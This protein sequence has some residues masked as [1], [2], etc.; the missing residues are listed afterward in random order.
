MMRLLHLTL[1]LFFLI[2]C[3]EESAPRSTAN[4]KQVLGGNNTTGFL[5]A[6][7]PRLF[8]FPEDHGLHAGYRNE[9]WYITGNL[10]SAEGRHFGYQ[11]TF[12]NVAARA[13]ATTQTRET[14]ATAASSN[15]NSER[16]WMAHFA[17][18][19]V[20]ANSH[21]A[22]E[23]FSR[24]NPG[25]AGAQLNPFKVWLDDWQLVG[26]GNDFPWHLK[27]TDQELSL[28]L[29]LNSVKKPVL[30]GDQGLSQKNQT[31]GSAS[32]YYS[33]TRLQTSGE[34]KVGDE[35][36]TVSGNSWLDREWSSSV[37]GPDQ[38]GWDWFSLQ[39]DDGQELMYYQL[40][41]LNGQSHAYSQ[42]NWTDA[43]ATQHLISPA[44]INLQEQQWWTSPA[45]VQYATAWLLSYQGRQWRVQAVV[46]AQWMDLSFQYW[47]GAVNVLDPVNG[48]V[49]G[50]GYLEM[51]RQ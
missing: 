47:E 11:V 41:N 44:D 23:R 22:V 18:T 30:Q 33:L 3:A 7:S 1:C 51:V 49:L 48:S 28:S 34:I 4:I 14:T 37:L 40:R 26:T 17:L 24:E 16:L 42:G 36:F 6:D 29:N 32:Y 46:D 35:L 10:Y 20:D 2:A 9:W 39:F 21:H 8:E 15:W 27:L 19:D 13:P 12:F 25:L 31:A 50:S 5:R 38:S 43:A 45:G